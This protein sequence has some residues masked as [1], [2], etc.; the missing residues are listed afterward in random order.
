MR[1]VSSGFDA[2]RSGFPALRLMATLKAARDFGLGQMAVNAI[3]VHFDPREPDVDVVAD[4]LAAALLRR[5]TLALP[6]AV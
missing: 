3:A 6:D 4:A 2:R 5:N 1:H